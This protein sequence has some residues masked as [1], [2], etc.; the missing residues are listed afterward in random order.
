MVGRSR[1]VQ[2]SGLRLEGRA[3]VEVVGAVGL[4]R[5]GCVG[6]YASFDLGLG[7]QRSCCGG[8]VRDPGL[9]GKVVGLTRV[10]L[11]RMVACP[12]VA[13]YVQAVEGAS[14]RMKTGDVMA[15]AR[16]TDVAGLQ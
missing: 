13:L 8:R 10:A 11:R 12:V 5:G 15:V 14:Q 16:P 2:R 3:E 9:D 4:R 7:G 6:W 1:G